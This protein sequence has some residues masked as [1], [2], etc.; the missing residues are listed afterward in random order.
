MILSKREAG[1][2]GD[3]RSGEQGTIRAR[4]WETSGARRRGNKNS[5]LDNLKSKIII[6]Y[7]VLIFTKW[8]SP[9]WQY[10]T[11]EY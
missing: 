3:E 8:L 6:N 4:G 2:R 5:S 1:E 11:L 9:T 10:E 7:A